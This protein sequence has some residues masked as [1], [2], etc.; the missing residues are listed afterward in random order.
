MISAAKSEEKS[1]G[2]PLWS[3][4]FVRAD[5]TVIA[6]KWTFIVNQSGTAD[7]PSLNFLRD[8][9]YILIRRNING[10]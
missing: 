5:G 6:L 2:E 7:N 9:F 1:L 10:L 4:F 3:S 8:G